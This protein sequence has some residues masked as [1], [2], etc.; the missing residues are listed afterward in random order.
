MGLM[1]PTT[2]LLALSVS[3]RP[4]CPM[5][6][7]LQDVAESPTLYPQYQKSLAHKLNQITKKL[8]EIVLIPDV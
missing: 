5:F 6:G 4:F 3:Y 8:C 2:W 7:L 1:G